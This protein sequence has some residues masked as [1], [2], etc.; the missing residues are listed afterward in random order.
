MKK[1]L[2]L[3]LAVLTV[4]T[5]SVTAFAAPVDSSTENY[6]KYLV[7][8][9]TS[10]YTKED[11][12]K[13][14]YGAGAPSVYSDTILTSW[15]DSCPKDDC[16]GVAYFY[17]ENGLIYWKCTKCGKTGTMSATPIDGKP[18]NGGTV[19]TPAALT[20]TTCGKSDKMVYI[21]TGVKD[22]KVYDIYYCSRCQ[23]LAYVLSTSHDKGS[24]GIGSR[25]CPAKNC[26]KT[27]TF[28]DYYLKDG[29]VV[30]R[31]VCPDGH[32]NDYIVSNSIEDY[33]AQ[34]HY[35]GY[36]TVVVTTVPG[37]TYEISDTY[38]KYGE[39]KTVTF[40]PKAGY[41]LTDVK[42]NGVSVAFQNNKV[43]FTV[44]CD[45]T[46]RPTFT[47]AEEL[48]EYSITVKSAGNGT[49]YAAKNGVQLGSTAKITAKSKDTVALTFQPTS[50][51][52]VSDVKIDGK[53]IGAVSTYSFKNLSADHSVEVTFA[54]NSPYADVEAKYE[55]A[56]EYVTRA[57][58]MGAYTK[59]GPTSY[60][61]GRTGISVGDLVAALA[62]LSDT[63]GKL[64]SDS[65]RRTWAINYGIVAKDTEFSAN[66]NVQT[67]CAIVQNYLKALED[68]NKV[69]FTRL[70]HTATV[71]QNAISLN[72]ATGKTFDGN[73][74]LHRYD[75]ASICLLIARLEYKG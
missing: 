25:T 39:Q 19:P 21:E 2:A 57:G 32:I 5:L 18:S 12:L 64:N 59:N 70:G 26:N 71:R 52:K 40:K 69:T 6:L 61:C 42:I 1:T 4:I 3:V 13:A 72:L 58:I 38:A 24:S 53:S 9:H 28:K 50:G 66:C 45:T 20:C 8:Y 10:A 44:T 23:K 62:E 29:R 36:Y 74:D 33:Y 22:G 56:V 68:L 35:F 16:D 34:N 60:F 54:W 11:V 37:G 41:V 27:A 14:L 63:A 15:I 65:E 31:F 46:V 43:T 48:K 49:V 30:A 47:K 51:N 67:A 7:G 55:T 73:R 75:L 17:V